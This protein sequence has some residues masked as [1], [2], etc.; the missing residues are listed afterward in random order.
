MIPTYTELSKLNFYSSFLVDF[1][2]FV[3][4]SPNTS[5][6]F[7]VSR[8]DHIRPIPH[9]TPHSSIVAVWVLT[10]DFVPS[11]LKTV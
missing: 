7:L 11:D 4:L 3:Y 2:F 5:S 6:V 8:L 9:S 1:F 10:S